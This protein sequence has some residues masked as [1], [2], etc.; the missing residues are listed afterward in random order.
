MERRDDAGGSVEFVCD[1]HVGQARA[2]GY[3]VGERPDEPGLV[4]VCGCPRGTHKVL[5]EG[6]RGRCIM[7]FP[8]VDGVTRPCGCWRFRGV[9]GEE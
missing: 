1:L 4:C 9:G 6:R 3:V 5:L 7:S 8:D 2:A